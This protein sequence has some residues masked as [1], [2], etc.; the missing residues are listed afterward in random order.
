MT[1]SR[2]RILGQIQDALGKRGPTPTPPSASR[3]EPAPDLLA[4]FVERLTAVAGR[5]VR[6]DHER[7]VAA[8]IEREL[9]NANARTIA[10]GGGAE[11]DALRQQLA[12][13]GFSTIA[14]DSP[15]DEIAEADAGITEAQWGVAETGTIA[16]DDRAMRA[17]RASLLPRLHIAVLDS[18]RMVATLDDLFA[19]AHHGGLVPH[20]LTLITGPSRTADIELQLVIGVH[21]PG[22]LCVVLR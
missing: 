12:A 19:A 10:F 11:M 2:D 16:L 20:A 22:E 9:R 7:D 3:R 15:T 21:G 5:C 17:R 1:S 8:T 4:R 6:P 14:S 13:R 18:R